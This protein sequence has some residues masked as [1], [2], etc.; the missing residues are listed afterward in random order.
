MSYL[1]CTVPSH[2]D[3]RYSSATATAIVILLLQQWIN[4]I[5]FEYEKENKQKI[6][7]LNLY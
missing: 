5:K 3:T 7:T 6:S 1:S 2:D 4:I